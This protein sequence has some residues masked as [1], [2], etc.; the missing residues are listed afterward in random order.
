MLD[1]P[2][3]PVQPS[4]RQ[5]IFLSWPGREAFYGG[6]AGG[7]KSYA[8]LM[9]AAMFV[10]EPKYYALLIRRTFADLNL[11]D[12]LIPISKEWWMGT[13]AHWHE[14][15]RRWTFPSGATISF[16]YLDGPNDHYRYQGAAFQFIGVDELTQFHEPPIRY[17]FSR[18]RRP[19]GTAIPIRF[20]GAGNPGGIGHQ[21]V[22][23]RYVDPGSQERPFIPARLEDN[24]H[25]D[26]ADYEHSL[27]QLDA[28]TRAQLRWGDW[29]AKPPGN[30]FRR[31][32]FGI[33]DAIPNTVD[34]FCRFWD[35][36]ATAPK[37]G[38]DPDWTA[39]VL[40]GRDSWTGLYYVIDARRRQATPGD[41]ERFI[42]A[43]A[44][45]DHARF[46]LAVKIRMEQEPGS[47]GVGAIDNYRRTILPQ[48]DF[49]GVKATG[50]KE[51][52]ANPL[53]G[54]AEAGNVKVLKGRW[55]QDWFDE[56]EAFPS[57]AHDDQVD[58]TSGA[59]LELFT[60]DSIFA[61]SSGPSR[62]G[63]NIFKGLR[64]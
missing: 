29:S 23:S 7:G 28:V 26:T 41:V 38:H 46:G 61:V 2:W 42:A 60:P 16:G 55:M 12:A 44:A 21:W 53:S 59:F 40:M 63:G 39:G 32:W 37:K 1:N 25:L 43:T 50:S 8:L 48:Y 24:P 62:R 31:E 11:P 20:R 47:S 17:L 57:D 45:E 58:A 36:A 13:E 14:N 30:K 9:A 3:I 52:R 19:E 49:A 51:V 6:A 33:V 34:V 22:A 64:Y 54:Q 4:V 10:E 27:A 15:E 5:A 35:L 56:M 18:L